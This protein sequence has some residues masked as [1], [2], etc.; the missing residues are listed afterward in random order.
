MNILAGLDIIEMISSMVSKIMGFLGDIFLRIFFS[1]AVRPLFKLMDTFIDIMLMLAGVNPLDSGASDSNLIT[2]FL[3]SKSISNL[4][5]YIAVFSAVLIIVLAI[6]QIIKQDFF[7]EDGVKKSHSTVIRKLA[8]G[9][10]YIIAIPPIFLFLNY[11]N[12]Y[13]T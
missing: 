9:L 4:Y 13:G 12:Y 10:L 7:S 6:Y 1:I 8:L 5:M 2:T 3:Q 11:S